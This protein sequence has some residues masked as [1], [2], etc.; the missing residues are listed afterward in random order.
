MPWMVSVR[1]RLLLRDSIKSSKSFR[2]LSSSVST[3]GRA[4]IDTTDAGLADAALRDDFTGS[5]TPSGTSSGCFSVSVPDS[6]FFALDFLIRR[7]GELPSGGVSAA[8]ESV[9]G[10]CWSGVFECMDPEHTSPGF[11]FSMSVWG[12]MS[13]N[14]LRAA[15]SAGILS[16]FNGSESVWGIRLDSRV[17]CTALSASS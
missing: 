7:A 6:L 14:A 5:T 1:I 3:V 4:S 17:S 10:I 11:S 2:A 8:A 9:W 13:G 16:S 12:M 15:S